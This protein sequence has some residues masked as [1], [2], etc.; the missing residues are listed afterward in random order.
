M[1]QFDFLFITSPTNA[2]N[3]HPPYYFMY[4]AAYLR[5]KGL[6]VKIIDSKGGDRPNDIEKHFQAASTAL[7]QNPSRFIGVAAFH[8]DFP[9][10][11][12]LGHLIKSIQPDAILLVGNAHA[13][14]DPQDF[15][16]EESP[17]DL[18]VLGEGEETCLEL[19]KYFYNMSPRLDYQL[20]DIKGIGFRDYEDKKLVRTEPR[21]FLD[22]ATLPPPA[23]DLIDMDYYLR[24]Q[25]LI[26][27]R[28]YTSMVCVFAGRGCP[29]NCDF[30]AANVVWKA[31]KG[32]AARLRN[33][34]DVIME[35][36]YL[37]DRYGIDF[38][39]LFDDMFGMSKKWMD[40][41]FEHKYN[42]D[43]RRGRVI[44]YACQ[45]RADIATEDM[46]RGLKETGCIQ[47]DVGVE[48]GSQFLLDVVNKKITL[49][50]IR[51]VFDWCRKYKMRSFA[52]MLLN[53]PYETRADLDHTYRFLKEIKPSAGV[54][55]GVTTPYPGTKIYE[56]TVGRLEKEGLPDLTP[57]KKLAKNEYSLLINNRLNPIER[58]RMALHTVDLERLWDKWNRRFKATPMF[59]R[60]WCLRPFQPLYW[61]AV[62][63]SERFWSYIWCWLKDLPKT[64]I[65]YWLHVLRLYRL[66][67]RLQY[68][69]SSKY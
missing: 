17:F 23:Y 41:W 44:P 53:L 58:F 18:A 15:I 66:V 35:V 61:K 9:A 31:N 13:T 33:V 60:M 30:C 26:I 43:F 38:F 47:V 39:Y 65:L 50:Q 51:Q 32:K 12:R 21:P 24:P 64:F 57:I 49:D 14:I 4:L 40:E 20:Y 69:K 6:K 1:E 8:S 29:F 2:R 36:N 46:I 34:L 37:R 68:G 67:K 59:E 28:I 56:G 11:M 48:S 25:K 63:S 27:R 5:G 42:E 16:E 45:T 22:L 7:K 3:P 19:Y 55:F 62:F 10:V 54:I 52:T